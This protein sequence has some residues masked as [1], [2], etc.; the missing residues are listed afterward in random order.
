MFFCSA[1]PMSARQVPQAQHLSVSEASDAQFS[2]LVPRLVTMGGPVREQ[3]ETHGVRQELPLQ[4][5]CHRGFMALWKLGIT[6]T[7]IVVRLLRQGGEGPTG[8]REARANTK[9]QLRAAGGWVDQPEPL[10]LQPHDATDH[11]QTVLEVLVA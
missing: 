10:R 1:V 3:A 11:L 6:G 8:G 7:E 5:L 9:D 4:R 2:R